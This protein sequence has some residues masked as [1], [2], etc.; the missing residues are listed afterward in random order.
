MPIG[1]APELRLKRLVGN[2]I[3]QAPSVRT[4]EANGRAK[5]RLS[6]AADRNR[7]ERREHVCVVWQVQSDNRRFA[8]DREPCRSVVC[9]GL[10]LAN[11]ECA[12]RAE[13]RLNDG[14]A[15]HRHERVAADPCATLLDRAVRP[16]S[17]KRHE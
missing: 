2:A 9:A 8:S 13:E 1:H 16:Q 12:R 11:V 5:L 6:A 10:R 4:L 3:S 14:R 17:L 15:E 7:L